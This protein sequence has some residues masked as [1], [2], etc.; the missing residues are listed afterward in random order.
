MIFE[1]LL[2][3]TMAMG[4]L[5]VHPLQCQVLRI[6]SSFGHVSVL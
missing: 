3:M 5:A 4:H 2:S 6:E 1:S